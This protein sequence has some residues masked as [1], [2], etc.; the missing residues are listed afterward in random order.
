MRAVDGLGTKTRVAYD[1]LQTK[2]QELIAAA[3]RVTVFE[4]RILVTV[5]THKARLLL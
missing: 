3:A 2:R 4:G 5:G 1:Q